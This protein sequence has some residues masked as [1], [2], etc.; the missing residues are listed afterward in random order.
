[1]ARHLQI[2]DSNQFFYGLTIQEPDK[3]EPLELK[4]PGADN[5]TLDFLQV[6]LSQSFTNRPDPTEYKP[7]QKCLHANPDK[8]W[9]AA[10]LV[11]HA[12][13]NGFQFKVPLE[14]M[15]AVGSVS[16]VYGRRKVPFF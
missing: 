15:P 9:T 7:L 11:G 13:F 16:P 1:M 14:D 8:R 5:V 2:F 10:E 4:L 12:Y 3:L 6:H